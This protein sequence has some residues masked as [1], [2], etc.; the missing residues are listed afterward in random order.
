MTI[1]DV[2]RAAGV[3]TATV[4]RVLNESGY[5]SQGARERIAQVMREMNYQPNALARSL[6]QERTRTVGLI[7]PDMTNAYFMAAARR[8]QQQLLEQDYHLIYMDSGEDPDKELEAIGLL[9]QMRVEALILAG[10]GA[11]A[12]LLAQLQAAGTPVVL[13]DRRVEGL[14]AD[15]VVEDNAAA[16]EQAALYLLDR[17]GADIGFIAGPDRV[18]TARERRSGLTRALQARGVQLAPERI[19]AGDYTRASG[20]AAAAHFLGLARRPQAVFS[21]NNEMTFGLYLGMKEHGLA[22]DA[23]EVVSFG[24]LDAAALFTARL[25]V[26]VQQPERIGEA[27]AELTLRRV[28]HK[29]QRDAAGGESLVFAPRLEWASAND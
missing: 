26:I 23:M 12:A 15:L 22:L 16:A 14:A 28:L 7:L 9:R 17:Y 6:K 1:K 25:S 2:A 27:A 24:R 29:Q 20:R 18:S 8:L 11:H 5:V 21:A 3:S 19:Y 13:L 4:S 10:T